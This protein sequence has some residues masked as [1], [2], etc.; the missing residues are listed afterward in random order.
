VKWRQRRPII[1][2]GLVPLR[3]KLVQ[4]AGHLGQ[5]VLI[6]VEV[7]RDLFWPAQA[8]G[9]KLEGSVKVPATSLRLP[10]TWYN[11]LDLGWRGGGEILYSA[12]KANTNIPSCEFAPKKLLA[13]AARTT[14]MA[15]EDPLPV[16][17]PAGEAHARAAFERFTRR[18]IGLARSQLDTRLRHKIDPEDVVQS[19]YKSFLIRYGDGALAAEGW[20]G[21]WGLLTRITVRKCADRVR[22]HR[23]ECRDLA[24]EVS[25]S[26]VGADEPWREVTG[27]EPTPEEAAVLAETVAH[28]LRGLDGDERSIVEL[29]LQGH[30]TTEIS[31]E[32]GRAERSVRRLRERVRKQLDRLRAEGT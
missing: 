2:F 20:D 9:L 3:S 18:L 26:P 15:Q 5:L 30:S 24:R 13:K 25:A 10:S 21:L 28:V 32:L 16:V 11:K 19:A 8:A 27:R 29:S 4:D 17:T 31:A 6:Q 1:H 12:F 14:S 23:A 22:Y 7:L